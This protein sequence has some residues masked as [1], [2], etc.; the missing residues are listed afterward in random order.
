[1][2]ALKAN[3]PKPSNPVNPNW[4]SKNPGKVSGGH[5]GNNPPKR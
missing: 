2:C 5:R 1:M 3:T 4:P